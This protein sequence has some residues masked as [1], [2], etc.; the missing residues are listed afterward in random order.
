M[1]HDI[2]SN[3]PKLQI[4]KQYPKIRE[5]SF[6]ADNILRSLPS[7]EKAQRDWLLYSKVSNSIY[8]FPCCLFSKA[9]IPS[10]WK[11]FGKDRCGFN[12]FRHQSRGI[13]M[14]ENSQSHFEAVISW[15]SYV[16]NSKNGNLM[17]Q[18]S[19]E[20]M[21]QEVSFWKD[22]LKSML[23]AIMFLARNNLAFRG[24]SDNIEDRNCGN[25]LSLVKLLGKFHPPLTLHLARLEK[26][27]I[28]YLSPYAQ[29]EFI[30]VCANSVRTAIL[31]SIKNR[32]YFSIL[33]DAT[34]DAS[35]K[36][37][38]SQ[39]IRTVDFSNSGCKVKENFISFINFE[40]KTG[41][42]LSEAI[43]EKLDQ[44]GLDI[45][46]CRGQ[47]YDNG[48]N[49]A[50]IYSGV[51]ARIKEKNPLA[52]FMPCA[53]HSLNL[54]GHNAASKVLEAKLVLGQIQNLYNFFSASPSR[55]SVLRK[56]VKKTLK[57]QSST[58]WSSRYCSVG[59]DHL[60][61]SWHSVFPS[62]KLERQPDLY[63]EI[64]QGCIAI[65]LCCQ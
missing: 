23:H 56:H 52:T 16:N 14:H 20:Q 38:I 37:Q 17:N 59:R 1:R 53:A 24:S 57:C 62:L 48:A 43:L 42:L 41:L 29:N 26:H 54:V 9:I 44:D 34:P 22:V 21:N 3:G 64:Q 60:R 4:L 35:H 55:W 58:R 8:C 7:G 47:G 5:C 46:N 51:Q 10:P 49:M 63:N 2:I 11:D 28:A 18:K 40:G 36:E 6:N 19:L 50:G 39:V 12:D 61:D 33:F 31:E 27:R 13:K 65:R 30:S 32:K 15:K 25:F 45:Q